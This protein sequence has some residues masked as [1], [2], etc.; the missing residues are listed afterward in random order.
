VINVTKS[1]KVANGVAFYNGSL[2]VALVDQIQRYDD[3]ENRLDKA[4]LEPS[5]IIVGPSILPNNTWHGWRYIRFSPDGKLY[6]AVGA[7]CNIPGEI[8]DNCVDDKDNKNYYGKILRMNPDG[9]NIEVFAKG[10]RNSVGFDFHPK[11]KQL[12]FTD[13]GRDNM[14]QTDHN[15]MP[16]DELNHAS[17]T[18]LH[19]GFPFCYG[20]NLQDNKFNPNN[21][22]SNYTG[23]AVEL[24]PHAAAIGMRFYNQYLFNDFFGS[25][26]IAEHGSWNRNPPSGYRVSVVKLNSNGS[27]EYIN[28]INGWLSNPAKNCTTDKDCGGSSKCLFQ[29]GSPYCSGW[30]R[31]AD[32][33][34]LPDGSILISDEGKGTIYRVTY[35]NPQWEIEYIILFTIIGIV[36]L[37]I[38]IFIVFYFTSK[39]TYETIQ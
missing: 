28:F 21:N 8:M 2:Y 32:I 1:L 20:K 16:P 39:K 24:A 34:I 30:G 9:S 18:G 36:V 22:C 13:N 11:T 19:F 25:V 17:T 27:M 4:P 6:L 14:N 35:I 37:L 23:A 26:I 7:P 33:E 5:A 38:I 12:W 3:V 10:I 15:N 29:Y 31:P